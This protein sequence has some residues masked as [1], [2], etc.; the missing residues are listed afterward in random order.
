[1]AD[2]TKPG[3]RTR[4]LLA[5]SEDLSDPIGKPSRNSRL[6]LALGERVDLVGSLL[7]T[8]GRREWYEAVVRHPYPNRV[9][10]RQRAGLSTQ[11]FEHLTRALG[12]ELE[13]RDP[14]SYDVLMVL[15]T[16]FGVRGSARPYAIYT[17]NIHTLTRRYLPKWAPLSVRQRRARIELE[18]AVCRGA[19][20]IF[21]MSEF[22]R[23]ALIADYGCD[24][25][26][27]IRV[28]AGSNTVAPSIEGRRYDSQV[29]L[30]VGL[31]FELKGGRVLLDAWREVRRRL[32][33]AELW[34]LGPEK[35]RGEET[36]GVRWRGFV[37]D[38][39]ELAGIYERASVFVLPSFYD[40]YPHALR[41]AMGQGLP[42]VGTNRG[43]VPENI[44]HGR[45]GLLVEPGDAG[46]LA[47]AI[48]TV[49]SDPDRAREMGCAGYRDVLEHHTWERVADLMAPALRAAAAE[50]IPER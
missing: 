20:R 47:E 33:E 41:E 13:R 43:G 40:A 24:P 31:N 28:G 38:R 34:I 25:D 16:L 15:Q 36:P 32:P 10:W 26:R 6:V 2:A 39:D 5:A 14:S 18:R 44:D 17:D 50:P 27:V 35:P 7:P 21:A 49:L 30:F 3:A 46:A 37:R 29:A 12:R 23:E 1:L 19:S 8:L 48:V 45:T 22:L 42:C 11:S 9:G 4:V